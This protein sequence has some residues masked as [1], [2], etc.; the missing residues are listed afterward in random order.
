MEELFENQYQVSYFEP[1][2]HGFSDKIPWL[3]SDYDSLTEA[4]ESKKELLEKGYKD[5]HLIEV[6]KRI[7]E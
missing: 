4:R 1:N 5:V 7:I 3:L 6:S 2:G